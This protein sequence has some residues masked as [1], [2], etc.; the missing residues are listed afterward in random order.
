MDDFSFLG[1]TT[2]GCLHYWQI[3]FK[4]QNTEG[5]RESKEDLAGGCSL[6][7]SLSLSLTHTH[8]HTH[9]HSYLIIESCCTVFVQLQLQTLSPPPHTHI[10]RA[11]ICHNKR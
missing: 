3:I 1:N 7:L 5:G 9:T 2:G 4:L 6:S 10:L 11:L 8:T